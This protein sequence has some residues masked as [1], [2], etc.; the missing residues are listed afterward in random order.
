MGLK[1]QALALKWIKDNISKFSGNPN[2]VTIMGL[3]AGGASISYHYLSR[4]SRNLFRAG[5]SMSGSPLNPW[6]LQEKPLK[7]A[8]DLVQKMGCTN[9]HTSTQIR[10]FLNTK[11]AYEIT[12]TVY[13]DQHVWL[14]LP[15]SPYAPVVEKNCTNAFIC[16][17]PLEILRKRQAYVA[18]IV[19]G[20]TEN[21]GLYPSA[22]WLNDNTTL[23]YL[24]QNWSTLC[25]VIFDFVDTLNTAQKLRACR[26]IK[27]V[28]LNNNAVSMS[29]FHNL[30][31]ALTH[32]LFT[33][34]IEQ[35]AKLHA[36]FN[37]RVYMYR[38]NYY[39]VRQPSF[40]E[41]FSTAPRQG[42]CHGDDVMML[43]SQFHVGW[44]R[45]TMDPADKHIQNVLWDLI[46]SLKT[47]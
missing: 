23:D 12:T 41:F 27:R 10:N 44:P 25:P 18:P 7:K 45:F 15:F 2:D 26:D 24:E 16:E 29:T 9:C 36:R 40:V 14:G 5:V 3:S 11:T 28:Y 33:L 21:E 20:M 1:D 31:K 32:R 34:G 30:T 46:L 13:N 8:K 17:H 37:N 38:Y 39:S 42:I 47:G 43:F 4:M 6:A 19:Y 22:E 35:N